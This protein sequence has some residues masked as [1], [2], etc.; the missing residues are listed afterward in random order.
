MLIAVAGLSGVGKT[1]AINHLKD[2]GVGAEIYVGGYIQNE[3]S[4]RGLQLT[5][6]N[7]QFVRKDMR[8]Q[9]GRD[10]FAKSVIAE[11]GDR[12]LRQNFLL[13]AIYAREEA[14]CYRK[15]FGE[16]LLIIGLSVDFDARALRL[17]TR[18]NR[19]LTRAELQKRDAY[20]REVLL[21]DEVVA[22]ADLQLSNDGELES[23]RRVLTDLKVHW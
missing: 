4:H 23:F 1:T 13:D 5:A 20:E 9:F 14:D 15:A 11:F 7:E 10:V 6:E 21:V 18:P 12:P 8:Q 17:A 2:E 16:G 3:V 22:A 19:P